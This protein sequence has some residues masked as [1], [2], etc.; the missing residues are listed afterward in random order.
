[1]QTYFRLSGSLFKIGIHAQAVWVAE[2][3][4]CTHIPS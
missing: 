1:M 2:I 4:I 3:P